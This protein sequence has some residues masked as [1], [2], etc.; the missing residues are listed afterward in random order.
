MHVQYTHTPFQRYNPQLNPPIMKFQ[1]LIATIFTIL[2]IFIPTKCQGLTNSLDDGIC[3]TMAAEGKCETQPKVTLEFCKKACDDLEKSKAYYT[4]IEVDDDGSDEF[5]ALKAKNWTGTD[6]PFYEF[7]GYITCI[8]NIGITCGPGEDESLA[9]KIDQLRKVMPYTVELL[10]FPFSLSDTIH[11]KNDCKS[12]D[13]II[14]TRRKRLHI[15]DM[16]EVNGE[17]G[18]DVFKFLKKMMGT[19]ELKEDR[20]T[21]FFVN[22]VATRIDVLEGASF[23]MLKKH[24]KDHL[25]GWEDDL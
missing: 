8:G 10:I 6:V 11:N 9:R 22:P 25:M 1:Q 18:H 15:M 3:E 12:M 13:K 23:S 24:I 2:T 21:F 20:T 19:Q 4:T 7:D 5:Y 17:G 14:S 16:V